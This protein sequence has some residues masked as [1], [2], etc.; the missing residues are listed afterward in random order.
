MLL[1]CSYIWLLSG[2]TL[3]QSAPQN[4]AVKLGATGIHQS[5]NGLFW[6]QMGPPDPDHVERLKE[7]RRKW[8]EPDRYDDLLQVPEVQAALATIR[9]AEG[10]D[11]N[12]LFGYFSDASRVFDHM[13]QVGHPRSSFRSPGGYTSSAAGAYQAMPDTWDEEV[14][15]GS[16]ENR[17]T[18]YNQD[19]FALA[20]LKYRGVLDEVEAGKI[21]WI[22]SKAVGYEW[23]SFPNAPYGQPTKSRSQLERYYRAQLKR[24]RSTD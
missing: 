9:F 23:A 3:A 20:R 2:F 18:P 12:R 21:G 14:R 13:T 1:R 4:G 7:E 5:Q 6:Q 11:Y 22:R 19:R 16:M 15:R 24:Y 17:F 10:A 8:K